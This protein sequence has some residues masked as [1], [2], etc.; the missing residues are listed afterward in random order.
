[1]AMGIMHGRQRMNTHM[2]TPAGINFLA[3]FRELDPDIQNRTMSVLLHVALRGQCSQKDIE[4][5]LG[6][7][8]AAASRNVSYWTTDIQK[9]D[10][11]PGPGYI[12]RYEDPNDRR[13]KILR[14]TPA[15]RKWYEEKVL[16]N[17]PQKARREL[18]S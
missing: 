13:F 2:D 17:A 15:G 6:M 1:M 5:D 11:K 8:N 9:R 3:A 18:A 12:E 4:R 7:S 16:G 10:G 14:L